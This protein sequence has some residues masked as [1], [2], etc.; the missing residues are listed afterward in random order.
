MT[1]APK[2]ALALICPA[3]LAL[4]LGACGKMV[5]TSAFKGEEH[6]VAQTIAKLQTDATAGDEQ[7]IC[8]NDLASAIVARLGGA[9]PGNGSSPP[10]GALAG[11][12]RAIKNQLAEVDSLDAS[13][14]SVQVSSGAGQPTATAR[15]KST[16][17][18]KSRV[19]TVALVKEGGK[20]K[21][22]GLQ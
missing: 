13:V 8:A 22:S 17:A 10:A 20:W 2:R 16:F 4:G 12:K 3:L 11:C 14:Q 6:E 1:F 9:S 21:V 15:V 18:G 5:S 19:H 7:K